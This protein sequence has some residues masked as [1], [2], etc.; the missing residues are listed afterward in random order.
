SS[1]TPPTSSWGRTTRHTAVLRKPHDIA[2]ATDFAYMP[3]TR[4]SRLRP[5]LVNEL[6]PGQSRLGF[7]YDDTPDTPHVAIE[8]QRTEG[9]VALVSPRPPSRDRALEAEGLC[10]DRLLAGCERVVPLSDVHGG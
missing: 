3:M 1:S 8:L 7:S 5:C 6:L 9:S 10:A 4:L 2:A